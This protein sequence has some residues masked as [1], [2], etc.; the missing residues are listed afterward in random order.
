MRRTRIASV[1]G[2]T[3]LTLLL[4][5]SIGLLD[6]SMDAAAMV[7]GGP[8]SLASSSLS[9]ADL[10]APYVVVLKDGVDSSAVASLHALAYGAQVSHVYTDS[11]SGYAAT[12]STSALAAIESDPDVLFVS[13]DSEVN[14]VAELTATEQILPPGIDRIDADRSSFRSG[15][16]RGAVNLN[17]AVID[18]GIDLHHPDL[19][20]VGG[21]DCAS[22]KSFDDQQGH[23]THVGGT[24]AAN[25]NGFGVVGVAPGARLWSVR[26]LNKQG[27]GTVA[28]VICGIDFV[29]ATRT[30]SD[31]SDDIA[32]ANVSLLAGGFDDENCGRSNKDALHLAI[33]GSVA[34]GV[35]YVVAA[36]N[37][38]RD[39]GN[40]VPAS[41]DEVL[42]VTAMADF[43][44]RPGGLSRES[45]SCAASV[46]DTGPGFPSFTDDSAA[47]F[48]DFATLPADQAHTIAGPGLCV[49]STFLGGTYQLESGTSQATPHVAGTVALC[50]ASGPCAGLTAPQ[51][52]A[53]IVSDAAAYNAGHAGYGFEGDPFRPISGKYFGCLIRAALY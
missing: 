1:S 27:R 12:I 32:V 31:P 49:L 45:D 3:V 42:T 46:G 6:R 43:D 28:G 34:A 4:V 44:G 2:I 17:L 50:I 51:I 19:N 15:D 30:N 20:V 35:T 37:G 8:S 24:I 10:L 41:Y 16:G 40:N 47:F 52:V 18:T 23:G 25:D 36:G 22:G 13:A 11:I 53:K 33:C 21:V 7:S 9:S 48:S 26:V 38:G 29:T 5:L 14:A 39:F